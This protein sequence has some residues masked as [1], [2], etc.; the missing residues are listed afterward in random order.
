MLGVIIFN[1][2]RISI[3]AVHKIFSLWRSKFLANSFVQIYLFQ[4]MG[5]RQ[6][7]YRLFLFAPRTADALVYASNE[8]S[9]RACI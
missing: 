4:V 7:S 8:A 1:L 6:N 2:L 3:S 9:Y 5:I